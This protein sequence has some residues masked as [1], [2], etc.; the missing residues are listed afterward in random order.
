MR[1]IRRGW[2]GKGCA[3][4]RSRGRQVTI[5]IS[6]LISILTFQYMDLYCV[7]YCTH[8]HAPIHAGGERAKKPKP[9]AAPHS[10]AILNCPCCMSV[11][12]LDCQRYILSL[13]PLP[14]TPHFSFSME[15]NFCVWTVN[16]IY[17]PLLPPPPH[18]S[19][20]LFHGR[21]SLCLDCQR[22]IPIIPPHFSFPLA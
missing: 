19:L 3:T 13:P 4:D 1:K 18:A 12:C 7:H 20:F 2:I 9:Q 16:G 6:I 14:P 21:E 10:D 15:G 11:L 5:L 8:A 17:L 22:Y